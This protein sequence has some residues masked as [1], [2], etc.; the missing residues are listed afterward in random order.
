MH[1]FMQALKLLKQ[2]MV[3][4]LGLATAAMRP[5]IS[6]A[7]VSTQLTTLRNSDFDIAVFSNSTQSFNDCWQ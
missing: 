1:E 4:T 5:T 3:R 2:R 7:G 6:A